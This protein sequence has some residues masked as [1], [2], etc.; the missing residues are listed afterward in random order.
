[1]DIWNVRPNGA[2]F[3]ENEDESNWYYKKVFHY[4]LDGLL[5]VAAPGMPVQ[6]VLRYNTYRGV[7][8]LMKGVFPSSSSSDRK[9]VV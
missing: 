5:F 3:A 9:S 4:L 6:E 7:L 1:M 2:S 8:F